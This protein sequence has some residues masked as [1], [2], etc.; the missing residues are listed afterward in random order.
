MQVK[1]QIKSWKAWKVK[2]GKESGVEF[3][4]PWESSD[5]IEG[6]VTLSK[7]CL[8]MFTWRHAIILWADICCSDEKN[9]VIFYILYETT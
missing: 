3:E 6:W 2:V 9:A 4:H 5:I 7:P 1:F 8:A